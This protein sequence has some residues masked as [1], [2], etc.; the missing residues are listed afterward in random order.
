MSLLRSLLTALVLTAMVLFSY[1]FETWEAPRVALLLA[2][3]WSAAANA[4]YIIQ[5]LK[6]R[7]DH[8][9]ASIAHIGFALVIFG[10]V[11]SNAKKEVVSQNR[12]GDL[13]MLNESLSNDEDL[14]LLEGDTIA[15]GP[16]YVRYRERRQSGI[17]AKFAVDYF[18]TSPAEYKQGEVVANEGFLFQ[19][20]SDHSAAPA[21]TADLEN[22]LWTFIPI[23]NERQRNDAQPW[24]AGK[25]GDFAFTLEPRIQLNEQ[26]G[27]APEPDT[28]RYW[29]KDL[30]THI[31]WGRVSD[32]EAD[33]DGWMDGRKHDLMRRD[34]LVIG[35]SILAL[36][37]ISA[38]TLEEKPTYG[39]LDKDLAVAAHFRL[40]GNGPDTNFTALYIVRDS[41]LIP[42]MVT[43]EDRGVKVRIDGFRP[44]EA[45][46]E[47]VIWEN[48]SIRRD[49][50]VMQ[51]IV[52]PQI[53]L[54]WLGCLIMT[55]GALMAV[56]QRRKQRV[57]R[58]A[59]AKP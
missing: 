56:R 52:F 30:Y 32:P 6:G 31:K 43:L 49:F 25:P 2:C 36:D 9:G 44:S 53:N 38:V 45:T 50:I 40:S 51:A 3:L 47:T 34:S 35:R 33:E 14:L 24:S 12:F 29:N 22:G 21:F 39:L 57:K 17:H 23:P 11:L 15:M 27:N 54:L 1:G 28:K 18:E 58:S 10:A 8:A 26:M 42:D 55:G 37:S 48:L 46:F 4:D 59:P 7:W 19:A 41:L 13:A 16:Y 5:V 20:N